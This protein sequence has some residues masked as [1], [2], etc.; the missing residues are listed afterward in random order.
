MCFC[1]VK[2]GRLGSPCGDGITAPCFF[3]PSNLFLIKVDYF[4]RAKRQ[5]EVPLLLKQYQEQKEIDRKFHE[6]QE[7]QKVRG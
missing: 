5:E 7:E 3:L 6:E 1:A 2:C 4:E